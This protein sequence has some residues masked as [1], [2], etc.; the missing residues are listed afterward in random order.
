MADGSTGG[1]GLHL[2]EQ[3]WEANPDNT[4]RIGADLHPVRARVATDAERNRLW[5]Q[6]I[7][8]FPSYGSFQRHAG[9]RTIPIVILT[10][11][12]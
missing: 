11:R 2:H 6:F 5:P 3:A 12:R 8:S 7:E 9:N 1:S 4:I 10:P